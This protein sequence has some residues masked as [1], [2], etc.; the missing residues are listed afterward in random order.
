MIRRPIAEVIAHAVGG[1]WGADEP[2]DES[3]EVVI[4][5]GADFPNVSLKQ[6]NGAPTR[7]ES[8]SKVGSRTLETGDIILEISGGTKD[9]PTGRTALVT[10]QLLAVT[11]LPVIAASF[12]RLVRVD[13]R[14]AN[15]R[16][17]YYV[18][19]DLYNQ[20][21]TWEFQ[22]QSTGLSNFQF[23]LFRK[24][25]S[26]PAF[27]LSQQRG[28]AEVLGALDDKIAANARAEALSDSLIGAMYLRAVAED[29]TVKR[30]FFEVFEVDFGEAFKG[31]HFSEPGVGR[32][33]IRI[34]DLKTF[35]S[36]VWT[37]ESRVRECVVGAGDVVVGMD[38]DFRATWWLGNDGLL[39]QRVCRVRGRTAG[40]AFVAEA[41]REPLMD[42][43]RAKTGTTVIHLNKSDMERAT[44]QV[45]NAEALSRFRREAEPVLSLRLGLARERVSLAAMR[46][47]LLPLLMSGKVRIRDAE[48]MVE[49]VV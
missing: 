47:A 6:L 30:P 10:D 4:I 46:D 15:A 5:R 32:P 33:L 29:G 2:F 40:P 26:F 25:F 38:A 24:R 1:G 21:G 36:Q 35:T 22:N 43:E 11:D 45:P 17:I 49:G 34:R 14:E 39:N 31:S 19:Q 37:T 8:A 13:A 42:I 44:V 16:F 3:R 7:F 12:C 27:P 20:G 28:I 9:R 18:L 48:Q 41:L 23:E